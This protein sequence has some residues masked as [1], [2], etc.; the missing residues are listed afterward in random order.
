L[1]L[2]TILFSGC[3]ATFETA[4][5]M[6]K[7]ESEKFFGIYWPPSYRF[8]GKTGITNSTDLEFIMDGMLWLPPL[9]HSAYLGLKQKV[10]DTGFVKSAL[11]VRGGVF[12]LPEQNAT[13]FPCQSDLLISLC[14]RDLIATIGGGIVSHPAYGFDFFGYSSYEF[15]PAYHLNFSLTLVEEC[16][17][18]DI[19]FEVNFIEF[20]DNKGPSKFDKYTAGIGFSWR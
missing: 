20:L 16:S 6:G 4:Q 2:S 5:T 9:P 13:G 1:F 10:F 19:M 7:G 11:L 12:F 18:R 14:S 17:K 8:Q 15:K 3:L